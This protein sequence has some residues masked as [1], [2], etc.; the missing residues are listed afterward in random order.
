MAMKNLKEILLE[1]LSVDSISEK[2]SIDSITFDKFPID[3]TFEDALEFL[4][5]QGFKDIDIDDSDY[6]DEIFNSEKSKC[7]TTAIDSRYKS[8]WFVDTLKEK[9]S[10]KNPIFYICFNK[11][12]YSVYYIDSED[13]GIDIVDNNKKE[14][15]KELNKRFNW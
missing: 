5:N 15:M 3:G 12:I 7:F 14:F 9:I 8:I 2:L 4:E 6:L 10:K 1:K 11:P 13:N